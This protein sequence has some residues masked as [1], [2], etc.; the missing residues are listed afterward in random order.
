MTSS[1]W[2]FD[3]LAY[4][5]DPVSTDTFYSDYYER[6]PLVSTHNDSDR[7]TN[8]VSIERI[9]T[10]IADSEL[11]PRSLQ[12][13]RHNPNVYREDFT[14]PDGTI[15]RGSAI[16]AYQE[17]ATIILPQMHLAD[18]MLMDYCR[19][20][21]NEF[22]CHVQTNIY[23]TPPSNQGFPSHYD[24]HDVFV[25]QV[26]GKKRWNL[27]EKPLNNPYRGE[28][29]K[30]DS[31]PVGRS[32]QEFVLDAGD[33]LYIPRGWIHDAVSIDEEPSLH[34]TVGLI[35]KTWADLMLEAISEVALR[36]PAFRRSLPPRFNHPDYPLDDMKAYF[37]D[38][39]GTFKK[40]VNF[41]ETFDLFLQEFIRSRPAIVRAGVINASRKI[42]PKDR[43]VL[44]ANT[45]LLIR[46][47]DKD[48]IV[49]CGGGDLNFDLLAKPTL[50][51]IA[52][53]ETVSKTDFS[54]LPD[55]DAIKTIKR[56]IAFGLLVQE[57]SES[58][59]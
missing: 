35:T 33:C 47:S 11:P 20:L 8:L 26:T 43:F 52:A 23:L 9:D 12:M 14:F 2:L 30:K 13:A 36:E 1:P 59:E 51:K 44:R 17:G 46:E 45:Q 37:D 39:V 22:G 31:H 48:C 32:I 40:E 24:N 29:F 55:K 5:V 6:K 3:P 34:V 49:I 54:E 57:N 27:Y 38:L 56:L 50:E 7:F 28:E 16:R 21:E 58:K 42:S 41:G 10:L 15:D 4:I 18:G 25:I 19:A 53:G